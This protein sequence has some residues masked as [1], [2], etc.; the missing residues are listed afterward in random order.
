MQQELLSLH[1]RIEAADPNIGVLVAAGVALLLYAMGNKHLWH[2]FQL[3]FVFIAFVGTMLLMIALVIVTNAETDW[4]RFR[5][6]DDGIQKD[7][8]RVLSETLTGGKDAYRT[9]V[10]VERTKQGLCRL[11]SLVLSLGATGYMAFGQ[12]DGA[13]WFLWG[14]G[15]LV[16]LGVLRWVLGARRGLW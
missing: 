3:W 13:W 14:W 7:A 2:P 10:L 15:L 9:G 8:A 12:K 16:F 5:I 11:G 4:L 6:F 1:R